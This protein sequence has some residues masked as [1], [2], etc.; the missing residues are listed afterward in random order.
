MAR[1]LTGPTKRNKNVCVAITPDMERA[2]TDL[3]RRAKVPVSTMAYN[4]LSAALGAAG[5]MSAAAS[6]VPS[7]PAPAQPASAVSRFGEAG[8]VGV[9]GNF[10]PFKLPIK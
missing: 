8:R 10:S 6:A 7:L 3:A 1:P 9:L 2:L 4:L 5:P